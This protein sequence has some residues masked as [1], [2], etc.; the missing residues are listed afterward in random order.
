MDWE[1]R[2]EADATHDDFRTQTFGK[3]RDLK[4]EGGHDEFIQSCVQLHLDEQ[5]RSLGKD[6]VDLRRMVA[7]KGPSELSEQILRDICSEADRVNG[8][9]A[10]LWYKGPGTLEPEYAAVGAKAKS[11]CPRPP[12]ELFGPTGG[13]IAQEYAQ[14]LSLIHI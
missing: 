12:T 1:A 14:A 3:R 7:A 2:S 10:A 11:A 8:D 5:Y 4:A 6:F 13:P 9:L